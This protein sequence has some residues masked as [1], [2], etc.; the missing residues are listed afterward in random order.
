MVP[1]TRKKYERHGFSYSLT[2]RVWD[3][4]I[5][6]CTNPKHK[7]WAYYGGR[8]ITVCDS[9]RNDFSS[10]IKDM[11]ERPAG[12]TIERLR[13]DEGYAP[14]N[15]VWA[16][17]TAQQINT[18]IQV[19]NTSGV[20]GVSVLKSGGFEAFIGHLGKKVLLGVRTDFFEACCLRKSA[21]N[22]YWNR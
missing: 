3:H 12:L 22:R 19:N 21:E 9:W 18:R 10:F 20:R 5:Q 4:M 2:Y 7:H 17:R 14:G 16:D 11:G 13:V 1:N 15:C 8:G 6:R